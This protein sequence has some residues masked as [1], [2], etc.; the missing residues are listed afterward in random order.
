MRARQR[1]VKDRTPRQRLQWVSLPTGRPTG[2]GIKCLLLGSVASVLANILPAHA[3]QPTSN[4]LPS[5]GT[6]TAGQASI[7]Q[8]GAHMDV[9]QDSQKAIINWQT[10]NIGRNAEVDYHQPNAAA[11]A[12]NRVLSADPSAILGKLNANGQ[13][14][15]INPNGVVFGSGAT[16]NVGGLVASVLDITDSDFLAGNLAFQ[17]GSADGRVTNRGHLSAAD[18]GYIALLA[19]EVRN[20]GVIEARLGTVALAAGDAVTLDM[21]GNGR[22]TLKVD[23]ATVRTLVDNRGMIVATD[24]QALLSSQAVNK[25]LGGTINV[26]G[27]IE[28]TSL[29]SKGG[30]IVLDASGGIT[31]A[32]AV[33]DA[34]GAT[35]GGTISVG[36]PGTAAVSIDQASRLKA[37]ADVTGDGG[38]ITIKAT[39]TKVTGQLIANGGSEG[40]NGGQVQTSGETLSVAQATVD[41]NAPKGATGQWL[42]DPSQ[43]VIAASGGDMTGTQLG[44]ALRVNNVTISTHAGSGNGDITV[45]D[46]VTWS[47]G[48]GL[49]LSARRNVGVNANITNTDSAPVTLRADNSGTN[50]GTVTFANGARVSTGGTVSIFYNPLSFTTP[51]DYTPFVTGGASLTAFMLVNDLDHLQAINTNL[52]GDYALGR[53]IDASA[54]AGM[55]GGAGFVPLGTS[56]TR[57]TGIFDG[58]NH[59]ISD[60]TINRP[61][62]SDVGL[63][64]VSSGTIQNVGLVG[65]SVVGLN[66]VGALVGTLFMGPTL[67]TNSFATGSVSGSDGVGGLVGVNMGTIDDSFAKGAVSGQTAVGGL[68][69]FG[70]I[71]K[72]SHATGTVTGTDKASSVGGLVGDN[73]VG[74][75]LP[76][77]SSIT[78]SFATGAVSAGAGSTAVGGL[79]GSNAAPIDDSYATGSV[80]VGDG[81]SRVGGLVGDNSVNSVLH[82]G[83]ISNSHATGAVTGGSSVTE[84]GGLVG[85]NGGGGADSTGNTINASFASGAITVDDGALHIGGLVGQNDGTI[86]GSSASG[87]VSA[88]AYSQAIGG[89]VGLNTV[90]GLTGPNSALIDS[91]FATGSINVSNGSSRIGGLVGDNAFNPIGLN[92]ISNSFATGAV[93]GGSGE[94]NMGGLVGLNSAN[95]IVNSHATG[96][97]T[98][99]DGAS[100]IGGLVGE[101]LSIASIGVGTITDSWASGNVKAGDI[102]V[103]LGGLVGSNQGGAVLL[104]DHATGSVVGGNGS[105]QLGGLAGQ[106]V[107][108]SSISDSFATGSVTAGDQAFGLGGLVGFQFVGASITNSYASGTIRA[109]VGASGLGGL[110]GD[111]FLGTVTT[112]FATGDVIGGLRTSGLG[113]LVGGSSGSNITSSFATGNVSG[114][115]TSFN[116]GGLVGIN[117]VGPGLPSTPSITSSFA[118][119]AVSAG[120]GSTGLGGLIGSN[121]API[122]GS[123]AT[124]A[125]T[126]GDGALHVGGLVGE[127]D[128]TITNSRASGAVSVGANSQAV[129]SLVGLNTGT[130]TNSVGT[131]AVTAGPG[132]TFVGGMIGENTGTVN[133]SN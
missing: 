20:D 38:A 16:V 129:G 90:A 10:Y 64:G 41:T 124:G 106:N 102:S 19:P 115:D 8:S 117:E 99:S 53:N 46:G 94:T 3:G 82:V 32:S 5:G 98:A 23:P 27:A 103:N 128:S 35:G 83:A 65:G 122:D 81:S 75:G 125:V 127:N 113:G 59:T 37:S 130:V 109:G 118:T 33:L 31:V 105:S 92:T 111:Q 131:G 77:T 76:F 123:F 114:G 43:F 112:S 2:T 104:R 6:V 47:T 50:V 39:T 14:V 133:D 57:F 74:P 55:N 116:L 13:I 96:A 120:A 93:T 119:G 45:N 48:N 12:L 22:I 9:T 58:E 69:G 63:F 25:L 86:T 28:A 42:I 17:R 4:A 30:D 26:G 87:A 29:S 110:L 60:L 24:G 121:S 89:L 67:V 62:E 80:T 100:G 44:N 51:T 72:N 52:S 15:L 107:F 71:I 34:S 1:P 61:T 91:S 11:M 78:N 97:V 126:S 132:S 40:G 95:L 73:L 70:G 108:V 54:T 68:V 85:F 21:T 7:S 101:N 88:G 84:L 56:A 18:G 66:Q 79:I 36:G 49:T